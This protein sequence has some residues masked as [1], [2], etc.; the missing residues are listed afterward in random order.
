M[1]LGNCPRVEGERSRVA[2]RR[3]R[4]ASRGLQVE[5]R[6]LQVE[7]RGHRSRVSGRDRESKVC[8]FLIVL[9]NEVFLFRRISHFYRVFQ[10]SI[11]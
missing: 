4:V 2:N 11:A 1:S 8:M 5:G 3:S 10:D 6:G 9:K 7:S